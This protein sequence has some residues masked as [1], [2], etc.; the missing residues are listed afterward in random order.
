MAAIQPW[1]PSRSRVMGA[2]A[3]SCL[4]VT[5]AACGAAPDQPASS[6]DR[7]SSHTPVTTGPSVPEAPSAPGDSSP[8]EHPSD[9]PSASDGPSPPRPSESDDN[10]RDAPRCQPQEDPA[11]GDSPSDG[12]AL[13]PE[14]I[15]P[16]PELCPEAYEGG[17]PSTA[18]PI[19][20]PA[21][22]PSGPSGPEPGYH[23]CSESES[24]NGHPCTEIPG[25]PTPFYP[26][27]P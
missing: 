9:D 24:L 8:T 6:G 14:E 22:E 23:P 7:S 19:P 27:D 25:V 3:V 11:P 12:P 16:D 20:E 21:P 4:S 18:P 10:W 1:T 17:G 15:L 5:I 26:T 13:S 2:L